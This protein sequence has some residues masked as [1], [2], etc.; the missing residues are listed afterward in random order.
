[1]TGLLI[2]EPN[3]LLGFLLPFI[4]ME[5]EA[6]AAYAW[7]PVINDCVAETAALIWI[8]S[9]RFSGSDI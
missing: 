6:F 7:G 3:C 5:E 9:V 2:S 8:V 1:M 4:K